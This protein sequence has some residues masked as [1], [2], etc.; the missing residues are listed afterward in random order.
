MVL[1]V[2]AEAAALML[3]TELAE[4]AALVT[5]GALLVLAQLRIRTVMLELQ[6]GQGKWI[7]S[8]REEWRFGWNFVAATDDRGG[9]T[10]RTG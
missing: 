3:L 10:R 1:S 4:M 8:S 6:M 2:L 5:P 9:G 7:T